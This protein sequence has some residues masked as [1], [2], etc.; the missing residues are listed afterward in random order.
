MDHLELIKKPVKDEIAEFENYFKKKIV[1]DVP[2]LNIITNYI[3]RSKGKQIRP[4][5]IFLSSKLVG[6]IN[7]STY[8]AATLIELLHTATLLHDDVVDESFERRNHFSINAI[9]KSKV[10]V[11]IGDYFLSSGLLLSISENE[12]RLLETVSESVK[13]MSEGELLQIQS[14]KKALINIDNYFNI[15]KKKT[16]SLFSA[17]TLCGAQ[18][19][20]DDPELFQKLKQY[21]MYIGIAFQIKD[22]LFDYQQKG[23]IGK[24]TGNDL[25]EKKFTLPL[26]LAL[27]N[28]PE[29]ESK[30]IIKKINTNDFSKYKYNEVVQ[31]VNKNNGIIETEKY[32]MDYKN[33][34]IDMLRFFPD[35]ETKQ[36][37][38]L[39]AEYIINRSR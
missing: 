3:L 29:N 18:S 30:T 2:L 16:A 4:L 9:W 17:C 33:K 1:S 36:S 31:F 5:L 22:D 38:K 25:K 19:S 15:I 27:K 13:A 12:Y 14:S 39:F 6:S 23:I 7:K 35:C 26:I 11:L 10:A 37:L 32:L 21:G 28:A 8:T 34:S 24:P 20:T